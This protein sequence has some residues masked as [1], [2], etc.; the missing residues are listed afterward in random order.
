MQRESNH[1]EIV[2]MYSLYQRPSES[3]DSIRSCFITVCISE[4]VIS[5]IFHYILAYRGS[6]DWIYDSTTSSER[7][8]KVTSVAS[9]KQ[10]SDGATPLSLAR[11]TRDTPVY[12]KWV[13]PLNL[14]HE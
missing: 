3:L 8:A 9:W 1:I 2:S 10:C 7:G 11:Q 12:T 4:K 14:P 13:W 5:V 6:L